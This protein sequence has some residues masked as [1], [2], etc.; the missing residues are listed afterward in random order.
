MSTI[1]NVVGRNFLAGGGQ[2]LPLIDDSWMTGI[3]VVGSNMYISNR[4]NNSFDD[5]DILLSN[6][7]SST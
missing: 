5:S 2:T 7:Q 1:A 6:Y 3:R 4:G